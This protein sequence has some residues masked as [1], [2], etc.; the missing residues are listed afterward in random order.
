MNRLFGALVLLVAALAAFTRSAPAA[1][2]ANLAWDWQ[3]RAPVFDPDAIPSDNPTLL[4]FDASWCGFC[5]QMERTTLADPTVRMKI[6]PLV[7]V[8]LDFDQQQELVKRFAIDGV[9]AFLLVNER[10]EEITRLV[11]ATPTLSFLNWLEAGQKQASGV[12]AAAGKRRAELRQLAEQ[13]AS[14][15]PADQAA[16]RQRAFAMLGRGEP[17]A[18]KFATDYLG[19]VAQTQPDALLDG[20]ADSDLAVR[21]AVAN[22]LRSKLGDTAAAITFDPW[23]GAPDRQA[24]VARLRQTVGQLEAK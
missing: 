20:L 11:G 8:K 19:N 7:H 2:P 24:Q 14:K 4:Y 6:E 15:D 23:A 5:K 16:V 18:Q 22:I 10:G 13:A 12:A 1:D 17:A 9:P 21:I 3:P